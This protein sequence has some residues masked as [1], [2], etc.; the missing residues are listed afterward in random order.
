MSNI[1]RRALL[2]AG[3]AVAAAAP[4]AGL[5]LADA[6]PWHPWS[7][8][9][10]A[11]HEGEVFTMATGRGA[12]RLVLEAVS[13]RADDNAHFSLLFRTAGGRGPDQ[14]AYAFSKSGFR[15]TKV[16]VVPSDD[17]RQRYVAIVNAAP[18]NAPKPPL[19]RS[20]TPA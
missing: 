18:R 5:R 8:A 6:T 16:F 11:P 19:R 20:G 15:R 14:G 9:T 3:L 1:S 2:R 7:R 17:T 10:W 12:H 4:F 13:G